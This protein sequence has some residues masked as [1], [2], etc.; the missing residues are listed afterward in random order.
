MRVLIPLL[1]LLLVGCA[2]ND[3]RFTSAANPCY[4][5]LQRIAAAKDNWAKERCKTDKD[6]PSWN[7]LLPYMGRG[8]NIP[9]C[10][11]GGT[12]IIGQVGKNPRCTFHRDYTLP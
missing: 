5:N 12:Y 6:T 9:V 2:Q 4:N 8:T 7:D 11:K 10:P 1:I 3:K